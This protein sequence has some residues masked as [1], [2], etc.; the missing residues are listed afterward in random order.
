VPSA[1]ALDLGEAGEITLGACPAIL[2]RDQHGQMSN[3]E[4]KRLEAGFAQAAEPARSE[5]DQVP[6]RREHI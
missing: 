6:R 3:A 4:A 1:A 2:K 5:T